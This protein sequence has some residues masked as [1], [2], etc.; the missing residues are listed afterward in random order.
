MITNGGSPAAQ[1]KRRKVAGAAAAGMSPLLETRR[2]IVARN[3]KRHAAMSD[4]T[5]PAVF[6]EEK[7]RNRDDEGEKDVAADAPEWPPIKS[8]AKMQQNGNKRPNGDVKEF[9]KKGGTGA[10]LGVDAWEDTG[11][12]VKRIHDTLLHASAPLRRQIDEYDAEYDKGKVKKVRKRNKDGDTI[13]SSVFDA[14]YTAEKGRPLKKGSMSRR[15]GPRM[16]RL[17]R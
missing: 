12:K 1:N 17:A 15:G 10:G 4:D 6:Y 7:D 11:K 16:K 13:D 2:S 9:L 14:A 3:G 8:K 5:S